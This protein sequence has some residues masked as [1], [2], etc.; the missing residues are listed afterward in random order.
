M[1]W[2]VII[3]VHKLQLPSRSKMYQKYR[4]NIRKNMN[5]HNHKSGHQFSFNG[6]QLVWVSQISPVSYRP[7]FVCC[8]LWFLTA[9]F[10]HEVVGDLVFFSDIHKILDC[11]DHN[12]YQKSHKLE[13]LE[14]TFNEKKNWYH[15]VKNE[16]KKI[17]WKWWKVVLLIITFIISRCFV[18]H[19]NHGDMDMNTEATNKNH[20]KNSKTKII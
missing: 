20:K 8:I 15:N 7:L 13:N 11:F 14:T 16:K 17:S 4:A 1:T 3:C 9:D 2:L 12:S 19:Q 5:T 6:E 18:P 10:S